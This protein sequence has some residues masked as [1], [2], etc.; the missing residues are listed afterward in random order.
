[1]D[2]PKDLCA[3]TILA[4]FQRSGATVAAI[5]AKD[6]LRRMLGKGLIFDGTAFCF[7]S[8]TADQVSLG[9]HGIENLLE[10]LDESRYL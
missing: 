6:K 2:R 4:A 10:R 3:E 8:E 5:A 1:M 7:S 9:E